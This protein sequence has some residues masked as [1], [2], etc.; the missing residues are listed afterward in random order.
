VPK[1]TKIAKVEGSKSFCPLHC[2]GVAPMIRV[3][4]NLTSEVNDWPAARQCLRAA[5]FYGH[6]ISLT[7]ITM[8]AIWLV[9]LF[10]TDG[11]RS[12]KWKKWQLI[13]RRFPPCDAEC[14]PRVSNVLLPIELEVI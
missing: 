10:N 9:R 13:P 7:L 11:T 5:R 12:W 2:C 8:P 14:P 4:R 1:R 3:Q 6:R